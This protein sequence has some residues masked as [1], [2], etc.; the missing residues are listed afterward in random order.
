MSC[1]RTTDFVRLA[2]DAE[3]AGGLLYTDIDLLRNA[4]LEAVEAIARIDRHYEA[5]EIGSTGEWLGGWL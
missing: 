3:H 2:E 5:S 1:S 4:P